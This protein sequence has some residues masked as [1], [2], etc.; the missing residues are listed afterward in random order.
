MSYEYAE[1]ADYKMNPNNNLP[2]PPSG[3]P[4][5]FS[6]AWTSIPNVIGIKPPNPQFQPSNNISYI[7]QQTMLPSISQNGQ[8]PVGLIQSRREPYAIEHLYNPY[9]TL[10]TKLGTNL[11]T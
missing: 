2:K 3:N 11:G 8:Y 10:S 9:G 6:V 7:Q 1:Y 5:A 4:Q